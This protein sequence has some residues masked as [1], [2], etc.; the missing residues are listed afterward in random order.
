MRSVSFVHCS[1][2]FKLN[3]IDICR[4]WA[5]LLADPDCVI[6]TKATCHSIKWKMFPVAE[7]L[8]F[9]F[10][11]LLVT[12]NCRLLF[13]VTACFYTYFK[14]CSSFT[15]KLKDWHASSINT[16][17]S[18][19]L[20]EKLI[21]LHPVKKFPTFYGTRRYITT[22]TSACHLLLA[23]QNVFIFLLQKDF[24]CTFCVPVVWAM[25]SRSVLSK[26]GGRRFFLLALKPAK[27]PSF[28]IIEWL[29]NYC[30]FFGCLLQA[31]AYSYYVSYHLFCWITKSIWIWK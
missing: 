28:S 10:I 23:L 13:I 5:W 8:H 30:I 22:F 1:K 7:S 9:L 26:H 25:K 24:V 4:L 18:R 27:T 14:N 29:E 16:P 19:V 3:N 15:R 12:I 21:G 6:G 2:I 11:Q 31:S 20:L 17:W